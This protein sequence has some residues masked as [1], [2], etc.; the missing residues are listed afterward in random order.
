MKKS[1]INI[2]QDKMDYTKVKPLKTGIEVRGMVDVEKS[3]GAAREIIKSLNL[4]LQVVN[5]AEMASY[6]AFEVR[7]A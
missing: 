2:F 1:D 6:G 3:V 7:E 4:N 5:T